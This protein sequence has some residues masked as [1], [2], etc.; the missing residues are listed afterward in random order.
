MPDGPWHVSYN[1]SYN[2]NCTREKD[3][4]DA[5]DDATR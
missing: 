5:G 1:V 4:K 3:L 2:V